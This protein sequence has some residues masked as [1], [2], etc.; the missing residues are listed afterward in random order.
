MIAGAL[1]LYWWDSA[2]RERI[3]EGVTIGGV[4]VGGLE[5]DAAIAEIRSTLIDPLNKNVVV[6]YR[7][8]KFKLK[9]DD[10]NIRADLDGMVNEAVRVSQEGG[11]LARSWRRIGGGGVDHAIEP[12]IAYSKSAVS[13]FVAGVASNIDRDPVNASV[14]PTATSLQP[15]SSKTGR[16]IDE[17]RLR[18]AVERALQRTDDRKVEPQV[19]KVEP[20]I[21][22]DELAAEYPTYLTVDRSS[23]ELRLYRNLELAKSY[24]VAIGAIGYDTPAGLYHIQ[25]KQVDPIWQVPNSEWAG[26]LAGKTIPPGPQNPLKARWMGI[27]N[28]A[29]IHGTSDIGSLGS[30]ASHGCIR[31]AITDVVDLYDRVPA[32]TPIYIA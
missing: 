21:T 28:G 19:A 3:S 2:N 16:S 20:E 32:G 13:Q 8:E 11:I 18:K 27:Y 7:D 29:G 26:D 22:T 24:T 12:R 5:R 25:S 30:A 10:L 23:F 14:E 17:G 1:L 15:V 4:D 31:M 6:T 9:P